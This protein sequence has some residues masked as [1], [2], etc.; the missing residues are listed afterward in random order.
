MLLRLS[1]VAQP[2]NH[3]ALVLSRINVLHVTDHDWKILKD[4]FQGGA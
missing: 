2:D 3:A 4:Q 1:R